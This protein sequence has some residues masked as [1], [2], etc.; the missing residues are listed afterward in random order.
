[1]LT[2]SV[3]CAAHRRHDGKS[4]DFVRCCTD[5]KSTVAEGSGLYLPYSAITLVLRGAPRG[6]SRRSSRYFAPPSPLCCCCCWTI[7]RNGSAALAGIGTPPASAN[8]LHS[9]AISIRRERAS[10]LPMQGA[11]TKHSAARRRYSSRLFTTAHAPARVDPRNR[12]ERV[13]REKVPAKWGWRS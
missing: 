8:R 7:G 10:S 5:M 4:F 1:M 6:A 3:I 9:R 2:T 13:A 11:N 12:L